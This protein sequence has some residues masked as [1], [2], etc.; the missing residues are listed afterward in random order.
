MESVTDNL[1]KVKATLPPGVGLVAVSKFHPAESILRCYEAG[2]RIFGES[3]VQELRVKQP[4]LPADI[5]WHFIGHLQTNKVKY[6]APYISLIHAVDSPA[7]LR[8]IDRRAAA[9]GR[10]IRCLLELH[11]AAEASKQGFT[12]AECR[13]FLE[14]G[15][16]KAWTHARICGVM[17]MATNTDDDLRVRS[18][19][20]RVRDFFD[21]AK[22]RWFSHDADFCERS[23]G[24]SHD[25]PI[26]IE[27]GAT[28]VRIG[29]SIFGERTT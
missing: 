12:P 23:Y 4:A 7:L 19:F 25:Y 3:R 26:A 6:I 16:W 20:A 17:C 27:Q 8:E 21:E 1:L 13:A 28:L 29:T 5:E 2:Q 11:V 22:E 9:C 14:Q 18:D 15:E 10:T 24:M